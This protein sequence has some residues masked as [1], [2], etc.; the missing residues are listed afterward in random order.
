MNAPLRFGIIGCGRMGR[1]HASRLRADGRGQVAAVFDPDRWS[2]DALRAELAAEARTCNTLEDL[3]EQAELEAVVIATPTTC[4]FEQIRACRDRGLG[5]LC[6]KPLA[7][8][9]AQVEQLIAEVGEQPPPFSLAYQRRGWSTYRTL[10]REVQSGRWGPIRSVTS[11]NSERWQQTIA[12]TWRDDPTVND[13]GFLADAGSH[14]L[15][16]LFYVTGLTPVEVF[17]RS[18]R[19]GSRVE[20][21]TQVTATTREGPLLALDFVGNAQFQAEDLHIHC[22]QADLMIRDHRVWR[23]QNNVVEPLEP[24]EPAAAPISMF[25]DLLRGELRENFAPVDCAGPVC[26][27]TAAILESSREARPV[28]L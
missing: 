23:A 27:L 4:H 21:I 19:Q 18:Q 13:G 5:I 16:A 6:E 8:T 2:A 17:A 15:D 1:L 10:R 25:L 12:G 11:H 9:A 26:R 14:K 24:L 28:R 3:L 20:I 7:A 22:E